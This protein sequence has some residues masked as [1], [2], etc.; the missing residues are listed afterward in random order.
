MRNFPT[1]ALIWLLA[2]TSTLMAGDNWP[3]FRGPSGQGHS[4]A[5]G[6]PLSWS[7]TENVTWK[8][9]I[10]G[11]GWSSPVVQGNQ[12]WMTTALDEGH[13]LR[14]ICVDRASGRLLHNVEVFA[15]ADPPEKNAKNSY[16][17]PTPVVEEGYV[18][19]HFGTMGTA[20]LDTSAGSIVWKNDELK[21]DHKEGPGSSPIM[22]GD[23]LIL[24]CDG[25]DVQYVAALDK[26]TGRVVWRQDRQGANAPDPDQ[27]KAYSTPLVIRFDERDEL[28]S[29]GADRVVAYDPANGHRLWWVD[30]DGYS[31][32]P[33]PL[34]AHGLVYIATGFNTPE[35]LAIR[36]GGRGDVT[37]T[38][39]VWRFNS[40]VPK[41]PSPLLVGDEI[42]MTSDKG[43]ATCLD[44]H[45]GAPV[46]RE[47]LGGNHSA[48]PVFA[49]A[50]I[51]FFSEEGHTSVLRRGREFSLLATSEIDSGIMASP[52]VVGRALLLRSE[53]H[54]YRIER[55]EAVG[56]D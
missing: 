37:E 29:T 21:L 15:P 1:L 39:V 47:R 38:H 14:A 50:R 3:Q 9:P 40:Q 25:M 46:W 26:R 54:L 19:V 31:N 11:R 27:R 6:L 55:Q 23:L 52:A 53:T 49:D 17:S 10:P 33:R 30:Y 42:Y 51:Y 35:L 56:Q 16:A 24:N 5:R 20:C 32:V 22:Y 45:T 7:E 12:I 44:A 34:F 43:V 4:D 8:V 48:S 2:L 36:P 13:S 28:V 18:Y 41:K